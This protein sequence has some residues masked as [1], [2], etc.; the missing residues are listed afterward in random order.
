MVGEMRDPKPSRPLSL[1]QETGHLVLSTLHTSGAG[2]TVNR[3]IDS[4][5]AEQQG[6]KSDHSLRLAPRH[7]FSAAREK[8][9]RA[10]ALRSVRS[11]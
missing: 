11:S 5:S 3:I 10:A 1:L 8:S 2:Q 7:H 6:I 4:F 9:L